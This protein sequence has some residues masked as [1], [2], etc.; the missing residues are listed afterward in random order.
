MTGRRAPPSRPTSP[1]DETLT[2]RPVP[3]KRAFSIRSYGPGAALGDTGDHEARRAYWAELKRAASASE[4]TKIKGENSRLL[5]NIEGKEAV[6]WRKDQKIVLQPTWGFYV[7][8]TDYE[9]SALDA[10]PRAMDNWSLAVSKLKRA[11]TV[12]ADLYSDEVAR[13]F[14][15][16]LITDEDMLDKATPDRVR[17]CFRAQVRSL[18]ITDETNGDDWV[19]PAR[20]RF[21]FLLDAAAVQMLANLTFPDDH[22]HT[23]RVRV[24]DA[25][26]LRAVA[27]AWQRPERTSSSYRG[28]RELSIVDLARV[29]CMV[30]DGAFTLEEYSD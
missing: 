22:T 26:R 3:R 16:D 17:K 24:L 8:L 21:C 14:K 18:E 11:S 6:S 15:L 1:E 10:L 12:P 28:V 19:P 29:Y 13:R 30:D 2:S 5:Q 20:N 9:Q 23:D 7:F 25:C 4:P 27:I